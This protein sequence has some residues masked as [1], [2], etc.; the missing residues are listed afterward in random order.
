MPNVKVAEKTLA[1]LET[2]RTALIAR[3]VALSE[4]RQRISFAAHAGG[5][6]EARKRLDAINAEAAVHASEVES[7]DAAI[8]EAKNHIATAQHAERTAADREAAR[9]LRKAFDQFVAQA[10]ALDAA[11]TLIAE[12][13]NAVTATLN[14]I[15]SLGSGAP[16]GQQWLV[17]GE[18]AMQSTLMRTP[19]ARAFRHLAPRERRS[20]TSLVRGWQASAAPSIAQRLGEQEAA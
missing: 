7:I 13:S 8:A 17:Y 9:E 18:M 19:W 6:K 10:A 15:H 12:T 11:L 4:E 3:G 1:D 5:D 20:F 16:T 2:K 14:A